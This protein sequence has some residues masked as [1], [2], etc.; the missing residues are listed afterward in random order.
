M[1]ELYQCNYRAWDKEE[2]K[3]YIGSLNPKNNEVRMDAFWSSYFNHLLD[4]KTLGKYTGLKDKND[5][6]IYGGDILLVYQH[7]YGDVEVKTYK[8]GVVR[9]CE[10]SFDIY[11]GQ[12]EPSYWEYLDSLSQEQLN[13]R[14][15]VIGNIHENPKLL[16]KGEIK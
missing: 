8:D 7:C 3:W 5:K 14:V 9:F 6:E 4:K 12:I 15:E 2:N 11:R 1:E 10:A 16:E 13:E